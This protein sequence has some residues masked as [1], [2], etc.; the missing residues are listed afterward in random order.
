MVLWCYAA[1]RRG[2]ILESTSRNIYLLGGKVPTTVLTGQQANILALAETGWYKWVY[3]R[4]SESIFPY[5][6]G[7]LGRCL[8]PCEQKGTLMS[9]HILIDKVN[10]LPYQRFRRLTKDK[11]RTAGSSNGIG[12]GG[13]VMESPR[14]YL[15]IRSKLSRFNDSEALR[16]SSLVHL[17]NVWYGS[18][19]PWLLRM[20]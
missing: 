10:V 9:Q 8:G 18:T 11:L 19:F 3:Y 5:P 13:G 6:V 20:C 14:L 4:D 12:C 16:C 2:K 1:D 7:H 15:M 17:R